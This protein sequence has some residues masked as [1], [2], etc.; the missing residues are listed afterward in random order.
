MTLR[1]ESWAGDTVRLIDA[2]G[3]PY[4][5]GRLALRVLVA[6]TLI[7][8]IAWKLVPVLVPSVA[9]DYESLRVIV[10]SLFLVYA[11]AESLVAYRSRNGSRG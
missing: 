10:I 2:I 9:D 5:W 3:R 4:Q 1:D 11:A 6:V 8:L 7:F